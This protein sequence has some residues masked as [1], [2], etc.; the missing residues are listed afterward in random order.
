VNAGH[1]LNYNNTTRVSR[2]KE[3]SELNTGH[4]IV[5]RAVICGLENAVKEMIALL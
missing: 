4:S 1:G 2:L 3:I 5:A